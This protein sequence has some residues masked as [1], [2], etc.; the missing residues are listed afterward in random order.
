M[1]IW[2]PQHVFAVM[3]ERDLVLLDIR[4]NSYFVLPN[5]EAQIAL[6]ADASGAVLLDAELAAE[7]LQSGLAA[8][9]AGPPSG[10]RVLPPAPMGD[11]F[12]RAAGPLQAG[13]ISSFLVALAGMAWR[14]KLAPLRGL[15]RER[16][17]AVPLSPSAE[18]TRRSV[19]FRRL[20]P[21]APFQGQCLYRAAL[22]RDWIGRGDESV[23]WVFG[24][25]T[26]PF[27]AHCWLQAGDLVLNDRLSHV[28][29]YSRLMAA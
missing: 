5:A 20:L 7:L 29:R 26:W 27:A 25:S 15:V 24:V 6:D 16:P 28:R 23:R 3:H 11:L 10:L 2:W 17:A 13:D 4:Q 14:Y 9:N 8:A 21:W 1:Q 22:L 19:A 18:T 12:D